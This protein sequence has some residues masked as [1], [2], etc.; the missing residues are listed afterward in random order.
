[1]PVDHAGG[2]GPAPIDL[3]HLRR[4]TMG[5]AALQRE[6][7]A[8]F[9]REMEEAQNRLAAL[10]GADGHA[11]AHR[12]RG[13]AS[14]VGATA[15]AAAAAAL[16]TAPESAALAAALVGRIGEAVSFILDS[17]LARPETL[18]PG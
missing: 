11:L 18:R 15:V 8:L 1:M 10:R 9:L 5:D 3:D 6:V 7:L 17:G 2:E 12:I 14:G 16:E 4:Q 13:A